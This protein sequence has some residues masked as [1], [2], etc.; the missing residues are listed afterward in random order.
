VLAVL[1]EMTE[2]SI[3][4]RELGGSLREDF[5]NEDLSWLHGVVESLEKDGLVKISPTEDWPRRV[6]EERAAYGNELPEGPHYAI[7][8]VSLP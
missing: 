7:T 1:R 5:D 8:R 2:E 3:P 6:A 4:L